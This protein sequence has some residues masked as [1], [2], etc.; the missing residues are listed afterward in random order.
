MSCPFQD[1]AEQSRCLV[2]RI[3]GDKPPVC[4]EDRPDDERGRGYRNCSHY[5]IAICG[6]LAKVLQMARKDRK[7][8]AAAQEWAV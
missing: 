4:A 3:A 1:S 2:L 6:G 7:S 5:Q 8:N